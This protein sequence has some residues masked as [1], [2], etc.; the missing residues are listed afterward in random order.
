MRIVI[1]GANSYIGNNLQSY[2]NNID[3]EIEVHQLDVVD[4]RWRDFDFSGYDSVVHVAAIVHQ[5][6]DVSWEQYHRV[7]VELTDEI[8]QKAKNLGVKQFIF[9]SSMAVYGVEKSLKKK[10]SEISPESPPAPTSM[11]GKSKYLAEQRLLALEDES[12]CVSIVRPPNVYGPGCKGGYISTYASIVRKLPAIPKAFTSIKQSILYI[13]NLSRFIYLLIGK[14]KKGIYTPQDSASVSA[15]ELMQ[16][17]SKSLGLRKKT[18]AFLGLFI[19]LIGFLPIVIKGY[20]GVAYTTS[21]SHQEEFDY[22]FVSYTEGIMRTV[23]YESQ[24]NHTNL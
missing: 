13:D 2:I 10:K 22:Q 1:T 15:V 9:L 14:Q 7:N 23:S 16:C 3:P 17:I 8:A 20:G 24:H 12:F 11:Y 6:G 21:N 18:S 19:Y 5:K 4:D